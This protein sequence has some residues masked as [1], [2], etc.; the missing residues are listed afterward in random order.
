MPAKFKIKSTQTGYMFNLMAGNG[1]VIL[2]SER[3]RSR[4]S[5]LNGIKSVR[6]NASTSTR[7]ER[8]TAKDGSSY[9]V[10]K[11]PNAEVIGRSRMY[12]SKSGMENGIDAVRR[13]AGKAEIEE[14]E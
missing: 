11:A 10:L 12:T 4:A 9:F 3:Y 14:A 13:C 6:K 7:F 8:R 1:H 2:I 5:L